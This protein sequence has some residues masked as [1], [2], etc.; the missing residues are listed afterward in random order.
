MSSQA[1]ADINAKKW[2]RLVSLIIGLLMEAAS[3]FLAACRREAP[4]AD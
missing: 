4:M 2:M 1:E 3:F